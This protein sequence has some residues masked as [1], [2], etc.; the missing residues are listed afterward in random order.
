M[1][2]VASGNRQAYAV[3]YSSYMPRL[4]HYLLPLLNE[5]KQDTEE[6]IQEVFLGIWEKRASLVAVQSFRAYVF[7]IARNKLVDLH[8]ARKAQSRLAGRVQIIT[9]QQVITPEEDVLFIQYNKVAHEAIGRLSPK[10][11]EI[12]RLSTQEELSMPEIAEKLGIS[13]SV[14]KKQL[15]AARQFVKNYLQHN[16]EWMVISFFLLRLHNIL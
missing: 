15:Y 16:A 8:R 1:Q 3:L 11:R 9:K 2:Q 6:I 10:K 5:S 4:Y 14:V 7:R 12:F 13:R